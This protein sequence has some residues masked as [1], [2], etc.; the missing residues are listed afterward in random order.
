MN[1]KRIS[2]RIAITAASALLAMSVAS[3]GGSSGSVSEKVAEKATGSSVELNTK[4]GGATIKSKNGEF[5]VSRSKELPKGW[6]SDVLPLPSGFTVNG[7]TNTKTPEGTSQTVTATG[8]GTS[9]DVLGSLQKSMEDAGV[10]IGFTASTSDGGTVSGEK[11]NAHYNVVSRPA[12]KNA[13][14]VMTYLQSSGD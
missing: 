3:C 14:L 7:S 12:G 1:D 6:P 8:P 10:K 13:T 4:D 9:K 11:G 2:R 5:S